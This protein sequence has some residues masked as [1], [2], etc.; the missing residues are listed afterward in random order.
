MANRLSSEGGPFSEPFLENK[1]ERDPLAWVHPDPPSP[2]RLLIDAMGGALEGMVVGLVAGVVVALV[3][4]FV[5]VL[6]LF[7][8]VFFLLYPLLIPVTL[9]G[10]LFGAFA[11]LVA[12]TLAAPR[13]RLDVARGRVRR[14]P[15][16]PMI[17]SGTLA[18][19]SAGTLITWGARVHPEFRLDWGLS[20]LP[21]HKEFTLGETYQVTVAIGSLLAAGLGVLVAWFVF[22]RRRRAWTAKLPRSSS[23][24]D[25]D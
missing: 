22:Q 8:C 2:L 23:A 6:T 10:P 16:G 11:G 4:V 1:D 14:Y 12:G 20:T 25:L 5:G 3:N 15:W 13:A 24:S 17:V 18:F 21:V 9:H 7:C 19:L